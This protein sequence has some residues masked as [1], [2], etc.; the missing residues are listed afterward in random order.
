MYDHFQKMRQLAQGEGNI[1]DIHCTGRSSKAAC[2]TRPIVDLLLDRYVW[3][4]VGAKMYPSS[5]A[6]IPC[7]LLLAI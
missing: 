4:G 7:I 6:R 3:K 1:A 5:N 2:G